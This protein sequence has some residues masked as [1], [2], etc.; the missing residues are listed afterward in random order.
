MTV[1]YP[2]FVTLFRSGVLAVDTAGA[3]YG[4]EAYRNEIGLGAS[5]KWL[6]NEDALRGVFPPGVRIGPLSRFNGYLNREG[7]W[8]DAS[9]GIQFLMSQV[10][11]LGAN[12]HTNKCATE[13]IRKDEKTIGVR[14]ADDSEYYADLV[15]LS[16]GSWT[17]SSFPE[18]NLQEQCLATG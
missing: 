14:C 10:I 18:L 6:D 7:G 11:A 8:A 9:Q 13:L 17:P 5:L 1:H 16:T 2:K 12:I 4:S 15:I 3:T